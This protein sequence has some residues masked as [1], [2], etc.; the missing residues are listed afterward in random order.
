MSCTPLGSAAKLSGLHRSSIF[1]EWSFLGRSRSG[2]VFF[3]FAANVAVSF[4]MLFS[5]AGSPF[6]YS[7]HSGAN[8]TR[9]GASTATFSGAVM[10]RVP[11]SPRSPLLSNFFFTR[12]L[13]PIGSFVTCL[14]WSVFRGFSWFAFTPDLRSSSKDCWRWSCAELARVGG[15]SPKTSSINEVNPLSRKPRFPEAGGARG[16][17]G[18]WSMGLKRRGNKKD[19]TDGLVGVLPIRVSN[20]PSGYVT[21]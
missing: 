1:T 6:R 21:R 14:S 12:W 16:S 15:S 11:N 9:S 18:S 19:P 10:V 7:A 2:E 17:S 8:L 3:R 5:S 20:S 4:I 13:R